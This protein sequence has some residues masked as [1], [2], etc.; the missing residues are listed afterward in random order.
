MPDA[1]PQDEVLKLAREA[2]S[3]ALPPVD[4]AEPAPDIDVSDMAEEVV[5]AIEPAIRAG[6]LEQAAALA[7]ELRQGLDYYLRWERDSAHEEEDQRQRFIRY[8]VEDDGAYADM[9]HNGQ[10]IA[11]GKLVATQHVHS[12]LELHVLPKLR[13]LEDGR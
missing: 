13:A 8:E 4:F 9:A 5:E 6:L 3:D 7:D 2:I 11:L 10:M 1:G 12:W